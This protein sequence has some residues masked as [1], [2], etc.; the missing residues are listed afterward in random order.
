[1]EMSLPPEFEAPAGKPAP[2][3]VLA[4]Q[5]QT[6]P[7]VFASPHSGRRYPADFKAA[8]KLDPIGLRRSED[9]FVEEIYGAAPGF[10]APLLLAHFPRAYVDPNREAYELDPAMFQ[11]ALPSFVNTGSPRIA[12]GLGTVAKVVTNGA[13]IYSRK[14]RFEDAERRIETCYRPYHQALEGLIAATRKKFGGCLLIDCHSMPSIGGPMDNDTG[15]RRVDMVLGDAHGAA[16]SVK[17]ANI[18]ADALKGAGFA[19][20]RNDPYAGGFTTR[21]YG[22]PKVG[23]HALQI[24]INRALY[25][26]EETVE[27]GPGMADL[28]HK[29]STLIEVLAGIDPA[30]LT[31]S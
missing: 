23:V 22:R 1:M 4:P 19:I 24:E 25:M 17:V 13:E 14:L 21:H 16:C 27:R 18:A 31:A 8:S 9:A 15:H 7:V 2:F 11:D 12:A 28:T 3:E 10:G 20:T 5:E 29:I 6:A 30:L 26:N